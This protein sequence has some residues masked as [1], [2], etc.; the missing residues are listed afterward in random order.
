VEGHAR[1][2]GPFPYIGSFSP[3]LQFNAVLGTSIVLA[4]LRWNRRMLSILGAIL[5]GGTAIVIPMTGSRSPVVIVG[6]TLAALFLIMKARGQW[7]RFLVLATIAAVLVAQSFGESALLQGW[8]ALAQRAQEAGGAGRRMI[9]ILLGPVTGLEEGGIWGYGVGTNHQVAPSFVSGGT[10][11]GWIGSDNRVLRVFVELGA[12]G[13]V[14]L[15]AL[16]LSLLYV[17]FRVVRMSQRPV[18]LIVG[19]TAFCV[20]L[21]YLVLPVVYNVVTGAIYWGSAG[22]LVGVWSVQQISAR[23]SGEGAL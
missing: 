18:E 16:K 2:T 12:L 15:S 14:V 10:W 23:P 13:W 22:A 19:G 17:A 8:Q 4:G 1:I 11:E 21:P 9:N 5:L 20:L 3:Y 6:G 7:L